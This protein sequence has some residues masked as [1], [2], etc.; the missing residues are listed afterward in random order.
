MIGMELEQLDCISY[1][2][3][4]VCICVCV[5]VFVALC[6]KKKKIHRHNVPDLDT[7]Y[8]SLCFLFFCAYFNVSNN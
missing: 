6:V 2:I 4:C 3:M 5:R 7:H 8:G 1:N